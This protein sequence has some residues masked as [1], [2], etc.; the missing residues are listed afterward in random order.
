MKKKIFLLLSII[1]IITIVYYFYTSKRNDSY[2]KIINLFDE[3]KNE[4]YLG[5]FYRYHNLEKNELENK[6][7]LSIAINEVFLTD[8]K[9]IIDEEKLK[10]VYETLFG[11]KKYKNENTFYKDKT[12]LYKDKKY[13]LIDEEKDTLFKLY[14]KEIKKEYFLNKLYVYVR[15]AYIKKSHDRYDIYKYYDNR[16]INTV[17]DIKDID[18]Y[19]KELNLYKFE[20]VMKKDKYYFERVGEIK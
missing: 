15:S 2:K 10:K 7:K 19:E 4:E 9:E 18:K 20:F 8:K 5:Y 13:Y 1:F 17:D 3:I 16:Y 14:V 12:V 11:L 6:I